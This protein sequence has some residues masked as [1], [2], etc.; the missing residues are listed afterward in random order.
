MGHPWRQ[1]LD[2]PWNATR[3]RLMMRRRARRVR[4]LAFLVGLIVVIGVTVA[5]RTIIVGTDI[6]DRKQL[7]GDIENHDGFPLHFNEQTLPVRQFTGRSDFDI[8]N[9]C[10]VKSSVIEHRFFD[11]PFWNY[12]IRL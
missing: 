2:E 11:G 7:I 12:S 1:R 10:L 6:G 4:A 9:L 5:Q 3:R 8:F